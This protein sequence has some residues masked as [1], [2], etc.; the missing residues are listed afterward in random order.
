M[1]RVKPI[2]KRPPAK[3]ERPPKLTRE[4]RSAQTR[5]ALFDAAARLVGQ[6]GYPD[7][8]I[9]AIT[10]E[11]KVAHGTFYNYFETRQDL[12][13]E[14]L[15]VLGK[16][17]LDRVQQASAD[18]A[19]DHERESKSFRAFFS[20]LA[21]RPE[22]YRILYEAKVFCAEAYEEHTQNVS[23]GYTR[24]L[25]RAHRK[26]EIKG[27][28][29]E[30]LEAIAFMLMGAREYIAMRYARSNGKTTELPEW[31]A[32]L[33]DRLVGRALYGLVEDTPRKKTK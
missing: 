6:I 33:Y 17:M 13:D 15:P 29:A 24:V 18:V 5:E 27:V 25:A 14:L 30:E 21:E 31:V 22:F 32:D 16:S 19:S 2:V 23:E 26:G 9:A 11:S 1:N 3:S 20:F 8:Q 12:F 10:A 7:T 4:A 28:A